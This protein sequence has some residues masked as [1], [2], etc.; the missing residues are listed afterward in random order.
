MA[1]IL[2]SYKIY[3][4]K[5]LKAKIQTPEAKEFVQVWVVLISRKHQLELMA[6]QRHQLLGEAP[7]LFRF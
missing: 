7:D 1:S 4:S 2:R 6:E 5:E 3:Y